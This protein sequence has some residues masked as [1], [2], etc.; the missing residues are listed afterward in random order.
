MDEIHTYIFAK[1]LKVKKIH[2]KVFAIVGFFVCLYFMI[3]I[4]YFLG[5]YNNCLGIICL[6]STA[7]FASRR[8]LGRR[9][10][11]LIRFG[12]HRTTGAIFSVQF[13]VLS[14]QRLIG[15]R[16]YF[17][18]AETNNGTQWLALFDSLNGKAIRTWERPAAADGTWDRP[19]RAVSHRWRTIWWR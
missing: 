1:L 3:V 17:K 2:C 5:V 18:P 19:A 9:F 13:L 14:D 16:C 12:R 11:R 15:G 8:Q 7:N 4:V 10:W 6:V